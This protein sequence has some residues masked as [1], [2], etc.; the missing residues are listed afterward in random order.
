MLLK[1]LQFVSNQTEK[2][3]Y[4]LQ[5]QLYFAYFYLVTQKLK[6]FNSVLE[7]VLLTYDNEIEGDEI[8]CYKAV[9]WSF[10]SITCHHKENISG[11]EAAHSKALELAAQIGT[12]D[13]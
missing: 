3:L 1:W 7:E 5:L 13:P 2:N 6:E 9:L 4:R 12:S 8:T 10:L 11:S